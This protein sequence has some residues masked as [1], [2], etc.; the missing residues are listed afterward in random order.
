MP[1]VAAGGLVVAWVRLFGPNGQRAIRMALDT[2]G[3]WH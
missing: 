2:G 3:G 1:F